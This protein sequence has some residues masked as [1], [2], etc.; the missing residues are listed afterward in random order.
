M[1]LVNEHGGEYRIISAENDVDNEVIIYTLTG[2]NGCDI[3]GRR[4]GAESLEEVREELKA[5]VKKA[6]ARRNTY[7]AMITWNSE[8]TSDGPSA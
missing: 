1:R 4:Y 8:L 5:A 3:T 7:P 2:S 6:N